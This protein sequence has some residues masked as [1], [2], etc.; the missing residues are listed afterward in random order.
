MN[1]VKEDKKVQ[2]LEGNTVEISDY[3]HQG[4]LDYYIPYIQK[5]LPKEIRN[6][7]ESGTHKIIAKSISLGNDILNIHPHNR[8]ETIQY[9]LNTIDGTYSSNICSFRYYSM[10]N[11][12]GALNFSSTNVSWMNRGIGS[13][14]QYLKE[15]L[16]YI[17]GV[18]YTSCCDKYSEINNHILTIHGGYKIIDSFKNHKSYNEVRIYGKIVNRFSKT[19]TFKI[20]I[21]D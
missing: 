14:L 7:I 19:R 5:L 8:A 11:C 15:D 10:T 13:L 16:C 9:T 20:K 6:K 18:G 3:S 21:K 17:N 2:Y 4:I 1:Q 12:C